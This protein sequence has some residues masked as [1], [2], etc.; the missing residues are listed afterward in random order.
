MSGVINTSPYCSKTADRQRGSSVVPLCG[1][2]KTSLAYMERITVREKCE[3]LTAKMWR[4]IYV[5]CYVNPTEAKE[6]GRYVRT[7]TV[8]E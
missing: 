7:T 3:I 1:V 4:L 2:V 6:Q 8:L 5:F